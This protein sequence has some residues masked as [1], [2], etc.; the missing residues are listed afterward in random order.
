MYVSAAFPTALLPCPRHSKRRTLAERNRSR[1][2][3]WR[4]SGE[5]FA[6]IACHCFYVNNRGLFRHS[7][8]PPL[9]FST[10][11]V[12]SKVYLRSWTAAVK[13]QSIDRSPSPSQGHRRQRRNEPGRYR[14]V[15]LTRRVVKLL[16][17]TPILRRRVQNRY[18]ADKKSPAN[19]SQFR[20]L[21][22]GCR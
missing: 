13:S 3:V 20:I 10:C 22:V 7:R 15:C 1:G 14:P 4:E 19:S 21:R 11:G 16:D 5:I 12:H 9:Q 18:T 17:A 6:W 8:S 2:L